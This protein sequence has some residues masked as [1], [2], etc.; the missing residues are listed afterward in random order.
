[1]VDGQRLEQGP[2]RV[3]LGGEDAVEAL[4]RLVPQEA[5]VEDPGP[6][7]HQVQA[8]QPLLDVGHQ[9]GQGVAVADV[10]LVVGHRRSQLLEG[11]QGGPDLPIGQQAGALGLDG[12]RRGVGAGV[13]QH[14]A[15]RGPVG[16][17]GQRRVR[18]PGGQRAAAGQLDATAAAGP[19]DGHRG[20][21]GDA[22]GAA[23]EQHH[24][25]GAQA[26]RQAPGGSLVRRRARLLHHHPGHPLRV[27]RSRPPPGP[28]GRR[29]RRRCRWP[30]S[31]GR[32]RGR[33]RGRA[34]CDRAAPG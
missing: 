7:D 15:Q 18:V 20:L 19:G 22:P 21:G 31:R 1:M 34:R 10:D 5:I 24:R 17:G 32:H 3:D 8:T 2:R 30:T 26:C 25:V 28:R 11:R 12:G 27:R 4:G 6:V 16:R 29:T 9:R 14:L 23:G 33:G 13:E